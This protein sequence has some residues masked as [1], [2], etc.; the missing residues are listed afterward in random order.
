MFNRVIWV[1]CQKAVSIKNS[2]VKRFSVSLLIFVLYFSFCRRNKHLGF[3]L[4]SQFQMKM[5]KC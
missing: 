3:Q 2:T 1:G 5:L 4:S